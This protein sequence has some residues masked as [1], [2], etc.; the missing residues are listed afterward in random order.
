MISVTYTAPNR[1]HHY[2]YAL[3]L[4][5]A[6]CLC[7][8]VSGYPRFKHGHK[9]SPLGDRWIKKD[10]VQLAY[11]TS[12][13]LPSIPTS[14]QEFLADRS[15]RYL[16][17]ASYPYAS[18]SDLFLAYNGCGLSTFH[19]LQ[20][21]KAVR[22]V[23]V[24]NS[25]VEIQEEILRQEHDA[26]GIPFRPFPAA[27]KARRLA[28]YDVA[29]FILCPSEF[30]RRSFLNKGYPETKLIKNQF[31]SEL[32]T[33]SETHYSLGK[34]QAKFIVLFVGTLSLRK[35]VRYL[36]QAFADLKIPNSELWLVGPQASPHGL[37]DLSVPPNVK[38]C[39][40]L[41][42]TE[43]QNAY[44]SADVFVLPTLEEGFT[45]S[46]S[47]KPWHTAYLLLQQRLR[48]AMIFFVTMWKVSS[49]P[50]ETHPPSPKKLACYI[51]IPFFAVGWR[52]PLGTE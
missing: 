47:A 50:L 37:N 40:V 36:V 35:G 17:R 29:D 49:F 25:H 26:V 18:R 30:V 27:E 5:A 22:V 15:K 8:F 46:L 41:K 3:A 34:H 28:E 52:T 32:P 2:P 16:D 20:H 44:R 4:N 10:V 11:L 48:V 9:L 38:I 33:P 24:V 14:A 7:A 45:R 19:R 12:L 43:L 23:E 42:G 31:G 1:S 21:Q 13:K 6:G 51:P 39:G